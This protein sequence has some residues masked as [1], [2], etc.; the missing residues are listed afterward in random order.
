MKILQISDIHLRGDGRLSFGAADTQQSFKQTMK[1]LMDMDPKP[2]VVVITGDLADNGNHEAYKKLKEELSK[3][4]FPLYILPGNHDKKEIFYDMFA[5][6]CPV[7][8][9]I[10]PH[11]CYTLEEGDIRIIVVDS[12][13]EGKHNGGFSEK[14]MKWLEDRM[15]EYQG[16][17]TLIF[18]HHPPFTTG[19]TLMDE[20]FENSER[21]VQLLK[22]KSYVRLC[23]GHM[24]RPIMTQWKG[25]QAMTC[26][27]VAML[28]ELDLSE[29]GGDTFYLGDPAYALH[30]LQGDCIN[31]H[32]CIIPTQA[33]YKGP[34]P[35]TYID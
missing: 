27:P 21:L 22:D 9:D 13:M 15:E 16:K 26:P 33:D 20:P 12:T 19:L 5:E 4:E 7:K 14:V 28:I 32:F 35:F 25:I 24:H 3:L 23:C 17:P 11:V 34:Y 31:T 8:K 1:H 18:T 2:D 30:D 10:Y 6:M 29:K